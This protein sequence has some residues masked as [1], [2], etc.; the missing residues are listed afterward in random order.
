MAI[1]NAK[2]FVEKVQA[3]AALAERLRADCATGANNQN[4]IPG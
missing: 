1:E 2:K 4:A 3:D